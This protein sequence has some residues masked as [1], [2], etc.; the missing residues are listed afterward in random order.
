MG[1][2]AVTKEKTAAFCREEKILNNLGLVYMAARRFE[3]R[4]C[5]REELIQIGT[6]GLIHAVDRFDEERNLAFSTYAV[7]LIIGEIQCYLRKDGP[8]H[9]GRGIRKN[10]ALLQRTSMEYSAKY[11]REA[12]L[13]ELEKLTGL[14]EEEILVATDAMRGVLSL[15]AP[16]GD[17]DT[18]SV[19][20]MIPKE[21]HEGEKIINHVALQDLLQN[22]NVVQ[23]RLIFLRYYQ[24]KTQ[25]ETAEILG[26]TQVKVSR[27]EK[28]ILLQLR[29]MM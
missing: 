19:G 12:T 10:M 16:V 1:T 23:Q 14:K 20:E 24:G 17:E 2:D 15:D 9:I 28:K 4:G 18:A 6:L 8:I 22:L 7:P 29:E 13:L 5:D 11:G 21:E 27:M 25:S 3:G 26:M